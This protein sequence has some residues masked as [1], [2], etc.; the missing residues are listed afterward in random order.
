MD[1]SQLTINHLPGI[2]DIS[3]EEYHGGNGI[4]RSTLTEFQKSPFHYWYKLNHPEVKQP[5][6]VI[7]KTNAL[8]FGNA[9]HTFILEPETFNDRYIVMPDIDRRTK[10]GKEAFADFQIQSEGKAV[11][12]AEAVEELQHMR[13]AIHS[14]ADAR[15]L[16]TG[17]IYE[18]SLYWNDPDTELLCKARPDI[19]Q[20]NFICDLK[21][22]KSGAYKDFQ[23]SVYNFGYHIQAGM[24]QEA[25]RHAHGSIQKNFIF[26]VI[27][28]EPPYATVVYQLDE[29]ALDLGVAQFKNILQGIRRCMDN[30]DW[31]SYPSGLITVPSW[32]FKS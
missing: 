2:Y 32:A 30:N 19:W 10:I 23:S 11:I 20:S 29:L 27:E 31:P 21:T 18:R 28:K 26:V 1:K 15:E 14:N 7:Q 13:D 25:L 3:I 17:A 8:E 24:I 5:A 22:T 12:S 4:S 9:V 16:I 6:A